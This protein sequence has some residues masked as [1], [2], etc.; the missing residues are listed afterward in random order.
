MHVL[1][2]PTLKYVQGPHRPQ[3]CKRCCE[4]RVTPQRQPVG[5]KSSPYTTFVVCTDPHIFLLGL[6][7]YQSNMFYWSVEASSIQGNL[8]FFMT[9]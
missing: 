9:H 8:S 1:K 2:R 3:K 4:S 6:N 7:K 5:Y